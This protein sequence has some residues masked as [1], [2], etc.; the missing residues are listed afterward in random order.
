M[1]EK[2]DGGISGGRGRGPGGAGSGSPI[3]QKMLAKSIAAGGR[4]QEQEIRILEWW[5]TVSKAGGH[6]E[7]EWLSSM[8][9]YRGRSGPDGEW[10]HF[11]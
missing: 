7:V 11:L 6:P 1:S 2:S 9:A 4:F 5:E 8:G 10:E 3:T